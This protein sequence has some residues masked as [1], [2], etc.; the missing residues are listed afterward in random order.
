MGVRKRR[1]FVD[2]RQAMQ[3][4]SEGKTDREIAQKLDVTKSAVCDWRKRMGLPCNP[5]TKKAHKLSKLEL[6]ARAAM[7]AGMSYGQYIAAGRPQIV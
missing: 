1:V 2:K 7:A 6:D 4:W 3:M 5:E